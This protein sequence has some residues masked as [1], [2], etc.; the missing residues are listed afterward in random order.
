MNLP[1][2]GKFVPVPKKGKHLYLFGTD[3]FLFQR[4]KS[5]AVVPNC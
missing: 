5:L 1:V 2:S 4:S 3:A